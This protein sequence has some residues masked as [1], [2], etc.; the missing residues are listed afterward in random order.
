MAGRKRSMWRSA[1]AAVLAVGVGAGSVAAVLVLP[2]SADTTPTFSATANVSCVLAPGTLNLEGTATLGITSLGPYTPT[3]GANSVASVSEGQSFTMVGTDLFGSITLTLP[4]GFATSI[5]ALTPDVNGSLTGLNVNA[6]NVTPPAAPPYDE[7]AMALDGLAA[8]AADTTTTLSVDNATV[9]AGQPLALLSAY[10]G[11]GPFTVNTGSAGQ[12]VDL[13]LGVPTGVQPATGQI[14]VQLDNADADGQPA[15]EQVECSLPSPAAAFGSIPIT[16]AST[17]TTT[18]S[19]TSTT[20]ST[21]T[22]TTMSS[23][24]ST[25]TA[26]VLTPVVTSVTPSQG[27]VFSIVLIRG[28]RFGRVKSVSFGANRSPAFLTLSNSLIIA[29]APNEPSGT[30]DVTVTNKT[31]TSPTSTGDEFTFTN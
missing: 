7:V 14:V 1:V 20:S 18:S 9:T 5:A 2:A 30:V 4:A 10:A 13:S 17:T 23:T 3:S 6:T 24:T 26:P 12:T 31:G 16:S 21:T 15:L 25:T 29:L 8:A 11:I 22:T 27:G 28:S 19:T